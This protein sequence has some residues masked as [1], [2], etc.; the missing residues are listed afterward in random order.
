MV[1]STDSWTRDGTTACFAGKLQRGKTMPKLLAFVALIALSLIAGDAAAQS[2]FNCTVTCSARTDP[3]A[4]GGRQPTTCT[5]LDGAT[6]L[7]TTN[8]A[9]PV[10]AVYCLFPG[11]RFAEGRSVSL[12]VYASDAQG[13]SAMSAPPLVFTSTAGPPPPPAGIT[14]GETNVLP[15]GDSG[16]NGLLLAQSATLAQAATIQSLSFYVSAA[17]GQLILGVYDA[18][19]PSGG[20]GA[21]KA[22]TATFTPV[23]GWNTAAVLAPVVLQ[24]GTYWLAY[25]PSSGAL[26]FVKGQDA[27]SSGKLYGRNFGPMP[28]TFST[29]PSSTS[30]HWSLY[31]T[32]KAATPIAPPTGLR[33]F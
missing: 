20:P 2:A 5:L 7:A 29:S 8:V 25:T 19:G 15:Q 12:T 28:A 1:G 26:A 6:I 16:N 4:P 24:P 11:L 18:T 10:G 14:M 31:G 27:S 3:F 13:S 30:S 23:A 21:K 33:V 9:G 22:E 32:L 17:G